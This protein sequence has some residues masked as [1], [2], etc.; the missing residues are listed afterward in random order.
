M[1]RSIKQNNNEIWKDVV[2]Y[3]SSYQVS[4]YGRIR[5]KTRKIP[6]GNW[7][8]AY[9]SRILKT[10]ISKVGREMVSLSKE[11]KH[12]HFQVHRLVATAFIPNT[13]NLPEINHIDYNPINNNVENL[14]WTT[15]SRNMK[16]SYRMGHKSWTE[17]MFGKDNHRSKKIA[18]I[19]NGR[20]VNVWD[21]MMDAQRKGFSSS[22]ICKCCK[23]IY[24][25]HKGHEWRYI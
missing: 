5:S 22:A 10:W 20:L 13:E 19:L 25:T 24:K 8:Q 7:Q 16:H 6:A 21:S 15:R 14:E 9:R 11:R 23:G 17:G 3:E 1:Q 2:D 12:K 18:Q 4:N